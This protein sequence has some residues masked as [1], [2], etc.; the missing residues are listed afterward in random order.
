MK[1]LL[2]ILLVLLTASP[3]LACDGYGQRTVKETYLMVRPVQRV[4]YRIVPVRV[5]TIRYTVPV[6]RVYIQQAQQPQRP[7][8]V[9]VE[10]RGILGRRT[11]T[12]IIE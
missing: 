12:T 4:E 8:Q 9:I 10:R 3:I 2:P 6:Q 7:R 1:K 11:R 5:E